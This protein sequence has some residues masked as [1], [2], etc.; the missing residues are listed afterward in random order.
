MPI[1]IDV[2]WSKVTVF[3][4]GE[5]IMELCRPLLV[6]DRY[7]NIKGRTP[8]GSTK[9]GVIFCLFFPSLPSICVIPCCCLSRRTLARLA[10]IRKSSESQNE[11][12]RRMKRDLVVSE[13]LENQS[14]I[15]FTSKPSGSPSDALVLV[16]ASLISMRDGISERTWLNKVHEVN[17][18]ASW[19]LWRTLK[20]VHRKIRPTMN[21][22]LRSSLTVHKQRSES[23]GSGPKTQAGH[24]PHSVE[25]R[26]AGV[27]LSFTDL[28]F[29]L[30][31][32]RSRFQWIYR[33]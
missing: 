5:H 2:S 32:K 17:L 21:F 3:C 9:K 7:C 16:L 26:S 18:S 4:C 33:P 12:S 24:I 14:K 6:R 8:K 1:K 20:L 22:L 27:S 28:L 31:P 23:G 29:M 11:K 10:A 13:L 25:Q 19:T 15:L 30:E